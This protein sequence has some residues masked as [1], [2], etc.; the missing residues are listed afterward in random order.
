MTTTAGLYNVGLSST[1]GAVE[2]A[3]R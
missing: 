2:S 3:A 1:R